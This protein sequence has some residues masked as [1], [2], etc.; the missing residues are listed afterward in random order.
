MAV[1]VLVVSGPM[2]IFAAAGDN[3]G[4]ADENGTV[5]EM[6]VTDPAEVTDPEENAEPVEGQEGQQAEEEDADAVV[7]EEPAAPEEAP[8]AEPEEES[9]GTLREMEAVGEITVTVGEVTKNS[10]ALSWGA[11]EGADTY[12]VLVGDATEGESYTDP[13][14]T[15]TGLTPNTEY[16]FKVVAL[17]GEETIAEGTATAK[18]AIEVGTIAGLKTLSGYNSVKVAWNAYSG[19]AKYVVTYAEGGTPSAKLYEGSATSC[20]Q[21]GFRTYD[22][23]NT[24]SG[25]VEMK[26]I[27]YKVTAYDSSNNVIAEGQTSGSP[28]RTMYYKLTFKKAATLTS[29]SGGKKKVKFKKKQVVYAWGFDG[30]RYRFDY[31]C[32]DGK[33]RTFYTKKVRVKPAI[34]KKHMRTKKAYDEAN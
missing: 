32:P 33:I 25:P 27:N 13:S 18:T 15:V 3:G 4:N 14:A 8:A 10:V 21:K 19:A 24:A 17:A 11:V 12:K 20:L 2:D 6:G 29:H 23:Y 9:E 26:D 5:T 34:W 7:P 28:V 30:G 31:K 1:A 22:V 16:T